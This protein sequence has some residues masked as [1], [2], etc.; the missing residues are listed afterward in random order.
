MNKRIVT[1]TGKNSE[2][3]RKAA[4]QSKNNPYDYKKEK[5]ESMELLKKMLASFVADLKYKK[6]YKCK[7]ITQHDGDEC[8]ECMEKEKI[9]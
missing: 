6:C 4:E 5:E 2:N 1:L 9:C 8:M 3:F 7:K